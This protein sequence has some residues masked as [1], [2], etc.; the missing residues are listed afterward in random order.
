MSYQNIARGRR[1]WQSSISQWSK[2]STIEEDAMG[3]TNGDPTKDYGFHTD[4]ETNPWWMVDLGGKYDIRE[5]R[6]YN[7]NYKGNP[8]VQSRASPILIETSLDNDVWVQF[9]STEPGFVFGREDQQYE[10]LVCLAKEETHGSYVRITVLRQHTCFHL[11][12][13]EVYGIPAVTDAAAAVV[14][15]SRGTIDSEPSRSLTSPL[16]DSVTRTASKPK[17]TRSGWLSFLG[18]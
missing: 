3:A 8:I 14:S 17:T 5:I 18:W 7:R 10:P 4:F 13:V 9:F 12:E 1:A 15:T 2:G 11:A 6:I 16:G